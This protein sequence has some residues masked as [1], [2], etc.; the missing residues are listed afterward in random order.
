MPVIKQNANTVLAGP[1]SGSPSEP[2]FRT[3]VAADIPAGGGTGTV[4]SVAL[5]MPSIFQ[6]LGSPITTSGTFQVSLLAQNAKAVLIGPTAGGT[7]LPTFRTLQSGDLGTGTANSTT[8]LRGDMTWGAAVSSVGLTMPSQFSVTGSP[9]TGSGTFA[10]A[11]GAQTARTFLGGP[12][13]GSAAPTFRALDGADI[14]TGIVATARLGTGTADS[15][16]YLRGDGT[17]ATVSGGGGS[18][19]VTSVA[20]TMPSQFS[21]S[22]S[23]VTTSGTLAVT[24]GAQTARTFLAGPTSGSAVPTFRALDGADVTTGTIASARLGS[25]TAD[26]TTFLRGDGTWDI[27]PVGPPGP[28][29]PQGLQG[30]QGVQGDPGPEGPTG[31]E[32]PEGPQGIQGP[33]GDPGPA[34]VGIPTGGATGQALTKTSAVDYATQWRNVALLDAANTF[35]I[36]PQTINTGAAGNKGII[37]KSA[38]SPTANLEEW[39]DSTGAAK[40]AILSTHG[41]WSIGSFN[42]STTTA[43]AYLGVTGGTARIMLADGTASNNFQIDNSNATFRY[44]YG[45]TIILQ[46]YKSPNAF[47]IVSDVLIGGNDGGPVSSGKLW[48]RNNTSAKPTILGTQDYNGIGAMHLRLDKFTAT[49]VRSSIYGIDTVWIDATDASR[50]GRVIFNAYDTAIREFMRVD[51]DGS[52]ALV[53]LGGVATTART[54]IYPPTTATV[55]LAIKGLASQTGNLQEWQ[56]STGAALSSIRSDGKIVA[57]GSL[58]TNLPVQMSLTQDVSGLK[59]VN[60]AATPGNSYYYGTDASGVKGYFVLPAASGGGDVYTTL[61]NTFV[62]SPQTINIANAANKGFVVKAAA[63]QSANVVEYQD[64]GGTAKSGVTSGLGI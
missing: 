52:N 11:W 59:L 14:T 19:S 27:G 48:V 33:Q 15:T 44:I 38:A 32:G 46:Y 16:T 2:T 60:D 25:G 42:E 47:N 56:D 57:N 34:G 9:I 64:S 53:S 7:G 17:W 24:W 51:T 43:G 45:G 5:T 22:G 3:L 1:T 4:T 50:K 31:P 55:A 6:V 23:P 21:V 41:F 40:S 36:G 20:L 37:V 49:N 35:T 63:S 58:L 13:S 10:V 54:T 30:L 62:A 39:Q 28:Q 12:T 18:G 8:F 26:A 29:G 61:A